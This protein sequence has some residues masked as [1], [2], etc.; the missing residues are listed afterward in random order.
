MDTSNT[1]ERREAVKLHT[2][3]ES[4][5]TP[6]MI[7]ARDANILIGLVPVLAALLFT[8]FAGCSQEPDVGSTVRVAKDMPLTDDTLSPTAT[9]TLTAEPTATAAPVPAKTPIPTYVPEPAAPDTPTAIPTVSATQ[10]GTHTPPP[11][12]TPLPIPTNTAAP[13]AT[14]TPLPSPTVIPTPTPVPTATYTA[15]PMATYT[16]APTPTPIYPIV[17]RSEDYG[18]TIDIPDGWVEEEGYIRSIPGGRLYIKSVDLTSQTTLDQFAESVRDNLRQEWWPT[19][20]LFEITS[21]EK[22]LSG[23][24]ESYI[25]EYRV[26]EEPRYCVVD[27]AEAIALGSSLPGFNRGFRVLHQACDWELDGRLDHARRESL[28][29]FRVIEVPSTYYTQFATTRGVTIKAPRNVD[30]AALQEGAKIVDAMIDGRRD[31]AECIEDEWYSSF[32]IFPKQF[33]VTDLPEFAYLKGKSDHWGQAYDDPLQIDGLGPTRSNPVTAVSEWALI[34]DSSY[35]YRRYEV[36]V[37]EFAHHLMNLCFTGEDHAALEE[38]LTDSL[39]MGYGEGLMINTDEFFAGLSEVYFSID[40]SIPRRHLEHFPS[41]V[42]EFLEEFYGVLTP[43]ATE[44]PGYVRYVTSSGVVLPW[45]NEEGV[46]FVHPTFGYSIDLLPDWK[47]ESQDAYR[48]VVSGP[49]S[50]IRIEYSRLAAGGDSEHQLAQIA[51]AQRRKWEQWTQGWDQTEVTSFELER[52]SY[53]IRYYGHESSQYC[54]IDVIERVLIAAHDGQ[55]FS[56]VLAGSVCGASIQARAQDIE[57][58]LGSFSP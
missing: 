55:E 39:E 15:T 5:G 43:A 7:K 35:P 58:M 24:H 12:D 11:T 19:A 6:H 40:G 14:V 29:S 51:E 23:D 33:P 27:V 50:T 53:W 18:Y 54:D 16:P 10:T 34:Q 47:V 38:F 26:H 48:T 45:L 28:E 36:A 37:H 17:T 21:F 30:P 25:L 13:V 46:E 1:E 4:I 49:S 20:S 31:I 52:D 3:S 44:V 56:V 32:A 42:M 41:G 8:I 57:T 9:A 22:R 2:L